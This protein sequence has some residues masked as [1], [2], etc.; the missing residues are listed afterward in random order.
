MG[1]WTPSIVPSDD[2]TV[3]LVVDDLGHLGLSWRETNVEDTRLEMIVADLLEGQYN[4]PVRVVGLNIAEGWA[5]DM[6]ED[7]AKEIRRRC[8]LQMTDAPARL[9][10]FMEQHER[11]DRRS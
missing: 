11:V 3:Y 9:V 1:N 7:V 5:R 6:S 8:D 10:D 2:Q 4:N